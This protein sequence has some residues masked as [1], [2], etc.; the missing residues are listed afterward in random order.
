M[1]QGRLIVAVLIAAC[2]TGIATEG[3]TAEPHG[4]RL[5]VPR[6]DRP[7]R[8]GDG[9]RTGGP[10]QPHRR[11]GKHRFHLMWHSVADQAISDY[12]RDPKPITAIGHSGGTMSPSNLPSVSRLRM[13]RV[14]LLITYDPN[15]FAHSVPGTST[16][17]S[18]YR[19]SRCF[20]RRRSHARPRIPWATTQAT[21]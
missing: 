5:S 20:G 10:H 6:L 4:A 14:S 2:L 17:T 15:R 1:V 19:S 13:S 12:R 11:S 8:L 7:Y 16:V 21:T 3:R 9:Q 18:T